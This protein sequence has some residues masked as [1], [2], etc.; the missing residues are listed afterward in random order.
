MQEINK[1]STTYLQVTSI[2]DS[3]WNAK[4]ALVFGTVYLELLFLIFFM[5]ALQSDRK[6]EKRSRK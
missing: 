4:I 2:N 1:L 6:I 5:T 3:V